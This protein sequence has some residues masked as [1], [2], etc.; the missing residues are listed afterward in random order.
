[1]FSHERNKVDLFGAMNRGSLI[2]I[3]TA[4]DLLKQDGCSIFGRFWIALITMAAEERATIPEDRR[5]A[6]MLYIDEAADYFSESMETLFS[7]L[8]KYK[9]GATVACQNLDQMDQG[10]RSAIMASTSTK[11]V[12]GLNAKDAAH[13]AR[14]MRCDVDFIDSMR[15]WPDRSEF[16]AYVRNVTPAPIKL[17]VPFGTME[18]EPTLEDEFYQ[19]LIAE[20]RERYAPTEAQDEPAEAIPT[21]LQPHELI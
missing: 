6:T 19:L 7:T 16:A 14:E 13:Y 17:T 4:K 1:M 9:V 20:N 10:L 2:L 21:G 5:R 12:G 3:N 18:R 15:K 8:R 11:I